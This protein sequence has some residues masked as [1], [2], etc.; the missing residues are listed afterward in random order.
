MIQKFVLRD[1]VL[2]TESEKRK[3]ILGA[4]LIIIYFFVDLFFVSINFFNR[5]GDAS[6][7]FVGAIVSIIC[8]L[9]IRW[10][11]VNTAIILQLIRCNALAF[12]F[13]NTESAVLTG[14]YVYFIP[15][16]L[17]ALAVFGYRERWMGIGF[18]LL[19]FI[20]FMTAILQ[21]TNFHPNDRHFYLIINFLIVLVIGILILIFFDRLVNNSEKNIL[22]KNKELMKANAELDRFVYSASHDLRAPLTSLAGLIHLAQRDK[23]DAPTYL[24]LMAERLK[25]MDNYIKDIVEYSRNT[26]L[27]VSFSKINLRPVIEEVV[28]T[29]KYSTDTS[30]V[31]IEIKLE[32]GLKI[33]TDESRLRVILNNLI[34]NAFKYQDLSKSNPYL[35]V[36]AAIQDNQ[37]FITIE[38]NGIGI[39]PEHHIKV[40]EM[41]YRANDSAAGSGLGLYIARETADK[42]KGKI[43]FESAYGLGTTFTVSI[44]A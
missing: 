17:G 38:D 22:Q 6:S 29:L 1:R 18:T 14:S 11:Y 30:K 26:R 32:D 5:V 21:P 28:N 44:P 34:G 2:E 36:Q 12:Y 16:S 3:I 37:C 24:A 19:S 10:K 40:F 8:L 39:K 43:S 7:L 23:A 13:S 42:L 25:V 33:K 41:F 35:K 20:L 4:Y 27:E 15:S 31:R 9:L